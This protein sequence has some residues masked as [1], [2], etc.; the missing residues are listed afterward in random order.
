MRLQPYLNFDGETRQAFL[1]YKSVFGGEFS[2]SSTMGENPGAEELDEGEKDRI[3]HISLPLRD[4]IILMG[5]DILPSAGHELTK[6]NNH[7]ISLEVDS[8][9][10]ADQLFNDLIKGGEIEMPLEEQFW[11]DYYGSL[12]DKFGVYWMIGFNEDAKQT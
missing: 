6:G 2:H 11:G 10:E 1:F 8:R 4:G 7:Y 3:M 5:S 9:E 12:K